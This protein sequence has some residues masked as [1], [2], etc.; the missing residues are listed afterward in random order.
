M[1]RCRQSFSGHARSTRAYERMKHS[2]IIKSDIFIH[3]NHEIYGILLPSVIRLK[4]INYFYPTDR[5]VRKLMFPFDLAS[6]IIAWYSESS[7]YGR[8]I[9]N[10]CLWVGGH[11]L[12]RSINI[13]PNNKLYISPSESAQNTLNTRIANMSGSKG[14]GDV[15]WPFS[16]YPSK[17]WS[18]SG[19]R[20]ILEAS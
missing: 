7:L 12:G 2:R 17:F 4:L 5:K 19:S 1:Y 11:Q 10:V 18:V 6:A 15:L 8:R 3:N 20:G 16:W 13:K 14:Q 9:S